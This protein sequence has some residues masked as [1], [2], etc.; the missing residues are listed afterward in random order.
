MH[1]ARER[2]QDP[3]ELADGIRRDWAD[4]DN[5]VWIDFAI[6]RFDAELRD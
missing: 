2:G 5:P 3:K 1:A 4:W 6:D